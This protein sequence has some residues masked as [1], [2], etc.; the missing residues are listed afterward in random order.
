MLIKEMFKLK[1][2]SRIKKGWTKSSSI[3]IHQFEKKKSA[4][5]YIACGIRKREELVLIFVGIISSN[6]K[7]QGICGAAVGRRPF[8]N[9]ASL[10]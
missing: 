6:A 4:K 2:D 3:L 5:R 7:Q 1:R 9:F 8:L 10:G